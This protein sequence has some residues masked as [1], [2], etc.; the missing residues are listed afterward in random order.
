MS[1][2]PLHGRLAVVTGAAEGIG[3]VIAR[4]LAAAGANLAAVDV[5]P[6]DL[7]RLVAPGQ[8]A[9]AFACDVT[10]SPQVAETC[11]AILDTMGPVSILVNNAGGGGDEPGDNIET[12]T[13]EQWE[14]VLSLNLSAAM[15]FC[16]GLVGSMRAARQ[17]RIINIS[18]TLRNGF[19][20]PVGTMRGRLPYI[21]AKMALVG[22]TRQL[23]NDLG[24]DG[25]TA[26][27]VSPGL[28]LPGPEAKITRR[29]NA[30]P[31]EEKHRLTGHIPAG[32]PATGEDVANAVLFLSL[33]S[34]AYVSGQTIDVSGG[35]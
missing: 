11:R 13:D 18:S 20:G 27:I 28:T 23:A 2:A 24:A 14:H 34:S 15:R 10:S 16:R 5:R 35:P 22:L 8:R 21:T 6:V 25:I 29:Y 3:A 32:R 12:L 17:G 7:S 33:P 9:Q 4:A 19:H 31:P 26:N 1:T 30:L